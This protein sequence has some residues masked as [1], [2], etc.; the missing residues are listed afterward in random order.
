MAPSKNALPVVL[1]RS[2]DSNCNTSVVCAINF[3]LLSNTPCMGASA[4]APHME[5]PNRTTVQKDH[6]TTTVFMY[7]FAAKYMRTVTTCT[8]SIPQTLVAS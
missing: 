5:D 6:S 2:G 8:C 7:L 4:V 3:Q 1:S